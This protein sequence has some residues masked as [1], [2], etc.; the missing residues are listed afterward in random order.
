MAY[1]TIKFNIVDSIATITLN[2]PDRLNAAPPQMFDEIAEALDNLE[3]ARA[4]TSSGCNGGSALHKGPHRRRA[5]SPLHA[6]ANL[7][8]NKRHALHL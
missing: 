6:L 3:G 7:L 1:E 2:R 8:L 4:S 5:Q